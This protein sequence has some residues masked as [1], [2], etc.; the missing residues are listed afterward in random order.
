M[1]FFRNNHIANILKSARKERRKLQ[2]HL[3]KG[4]EKLFT[5]G[6]EWSLSFR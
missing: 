3:K 1:Q 6:V 2:N 5:W 4:T